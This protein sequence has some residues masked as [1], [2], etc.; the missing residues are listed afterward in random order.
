MTAGEVLV[1]LARS[2]HQEK[3][4]CLSRMVGPHRLI[5]PLTWCQRAGRAS[6][7]GTGCHETGDEQEHEWLRPSA[8]LCLIT[9]MCT[10][11][12]ELPLRP[13]TFNPLLS[14]H[15]KVHGIGL[16]KV[17]STTLRE[18]LSLRFPSLSWNFL[19]KDWIFWLIRSRWFVV[20]FTYF[21]GAVWQ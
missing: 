9:R 12:V 2:S 1:G 10:M 4:N 19:L 11:L 16:Q 15:S 13:F 6:G 14:L 18:T 5:F 7:S 20:L 8:S 3:L 17:L 21:L